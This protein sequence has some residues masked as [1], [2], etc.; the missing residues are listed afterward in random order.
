MNEDELNRMLTEWSDA[1]EYF[2]DEDGCQ[3]KKVI[4]FTQNPTACFEHLIPKLNRLGW[5]VGIMPC[6][7]VNN[8]LWY[9]DMFNIYKELHI[10]GSNPKEET[11]GL[12]LGRALEKLIGK[13]V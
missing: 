2:T 13:E 4:N 7:P 8:P 12:A 5:G 10:R 1:K 3:H 11:P 9:A 6:G